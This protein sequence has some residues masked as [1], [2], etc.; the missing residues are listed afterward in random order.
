MDGQLNI[1]EL[2]NSGILEMYVMG[3][4]PEE[5]A[6]RIHKLVQMD[7]N[8]RSEVEQIELSLMTLAEAESPE[9]PSSSILENVLQE[10]EQEEL[11]QEND[12][13]RPLNQPKSKIRTFSLLQIAA[14]LALAI[15][16][17]ANIFLYLRL[18]ET[19]KAFASL[20]EDVNKMKEQTRSLH[21]TLDRQNDF[22]ATVNESRFVTIPLAT[23]DTG[24]PTNK[25]T[26]LFDEEGNQALMF[27]YS[28][29]NL[30][31]EKVYQL[32]AIYGKEVVSVGLLDGK[33]GESFQEVLAKKGTPDVFAI[34]IEPKGG[35]LQPS[36]AP[37]LMGK[38]TA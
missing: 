19:D 3:N 23:T 15:S 12:N 34:S 37:I 10:I 14:G 22:I 29:E 33:L 17:G 2:K 7:A 27:D 6:V 28:L 18:N 30:S 8:L 11:P 38:V 16:V 32:W 1:E 31:E 21:Q 13:I 5:E 20:E 4:L 9:L 25:A 24:E 35:S 36:S 26:V